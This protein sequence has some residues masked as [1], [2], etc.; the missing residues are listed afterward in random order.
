MRTPILA[1]NWKMHK[2]IKEA[3]NFILSLKRE[4]PQNHDR[5]VVICPPFPA[6]SEVSKV[7][8]GGIKLGAQNLHWEEKGAFTGEVSAEMLRD[9]GCQYVII[10]HSERRK[11][12]GE[13]DEWVSKKVRAALNWGLRPI[14][15]VGETLEQRKAGQ[16]R[17]VVSRQVRAALEGL[18]PSQISQIVIAYEP[19]WA[20]GTGVTDTPSEANETCGMIRQMLEERAGYEGAQKV[21]IQY[22]GSVKPEN[23]DGFMAQKEIDG[24]LVGGASLDV[25][26]FV[27]IVRFEALAGRK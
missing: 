1:A 27:R 7:L 16:T 22:G 17:E 21:R 4:L 9:A 12:F 25:A 13:S 26:A 10:G 11:Y 2:T 19:V 15:C 5:D 23:I 8:D 24:A 6:L 20:I 14:L 3:V 18:T